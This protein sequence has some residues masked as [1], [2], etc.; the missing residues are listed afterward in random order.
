M[1]SP[2]LPLQRPRKDFLQAGVCQ[3]TMRLDIVADNRE[4][5]STLATHLAIEQVLGPIKLPASILKD[6]V[7]D[8][9]D[10]VVISSKALDG[11]R[12]DGNL[13]VNEITFTDLVRERPAHADPGLV[14]RILRLSVSRIPGK[15]TPSTT[16]LNYAIERQMPEP[17]RDE[18][19]RADHEQ[20]VRPLLTKLTRWLEKKAPGVPP[21]Q[22]LMKFA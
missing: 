8:N 20:L 6:R 9:V 14:G 17:V 12:S 16:V 3:T 7:R 18:A 5:K 1:K 22:A 10:I 11:Q 21:R 4:D 13:I 15:V 19:F 2:I